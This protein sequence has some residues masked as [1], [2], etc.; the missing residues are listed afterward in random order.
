MVQ[1]DLVLPEPG[2]RRPQRL[3]ERQVAGDGMRVDQDRRV[4]LR[5]R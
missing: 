5:L 4:E 2:E 3:E 1:P